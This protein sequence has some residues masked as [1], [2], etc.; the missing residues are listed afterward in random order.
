MEFNFDFK[1][2]A[3]ITS[4]LEEVSS[5]LKRLSP[6]SNP[7]HDSGSSDADEGCKSSASRS[8]LGV[9][10]SVDDLCGSCGLEYKPIPAM[11]SR[12]L[13]EGARFAVQIATIFS[14]IYEVDAVVFSSRHGE[15][16]RNERILNAISQGSDVSP[17][18]FSMSVHNAA[19][20]QFLISRKL[21]VPYSSI[22]GGEDTFVKALYEL[23][24]FISAGYRS[25]LYVDFDS[26]IPDEFAQHIDPTV[27]SL[28]YAAAFICTSGHSLK[29][30]V[31]EH[32]FNLREATN[33][34]HESVSSLSMLR[35]LDVAMSKGNE[36]ISY[37][38]ESL[39]QNEINCRTI[40]Q[41]EAFEG[42][43][44]ADSSE[45]MQLSNCP[46]SLQ[47][48]AASSLGHKSVKLIGSTKLSYTL[49][50]SFG[51]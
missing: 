40:S 18:D 50:T 37:D 38:Q 9:Y 44:G 6:C 36:R 15:L 10:S 11:L 19:V 46:Q 16:I 43:I 17:T 47:F 2:C 30:D 25:V 23:H 28:A 1:A 7:D 48:V 5:C 8:F 33:F 20:G 45:F 24:A 41:K 3:A 21:R 13:S 29:L 22:S 14:N 12:R 27:S 39:D 31:S 26:K 34:E 49:T 4:S 35:V 42:K 51:Q 32:N